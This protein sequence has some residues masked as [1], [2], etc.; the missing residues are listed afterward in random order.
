[1]HS[2]VLK[3]FPGQLLVMVTPVKFALWANMCGGLS[4]MVGGGPVHFMPARRMWP[5]P[6]RRYRLHSAAPSR[7]AAA[8]AGAADAGAAAAGSGERELPAGCA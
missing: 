8:D 6:P 3:E 2:D 7:A 4:V 1:M 5:S